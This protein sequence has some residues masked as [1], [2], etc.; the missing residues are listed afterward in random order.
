M[1][2]L[3]PGVHAATI[4]DDLVF[5]DERADRYLCVVGA[6]PLGLLG[7]EAGGVDPESFAALRA[8]GL[9]DDEA[10]LCGLDVDWPLPRRDL[11][12]LDRN[13]GVGN[14]AQAA[15]CLADAGRHYRGRTF[16]AIL[17]LGR[18]RPAPNNGT[19]RE[20]AALIRGFRSWAPFAPGASKCLL[21]A[22]MLLRLLRRE[23][24][25]A[26]WVFAVRTWPFAAHCWLQI[27]DLALDGEVER[28]A[29]YVPILVI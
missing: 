11:R 19:E 24:L 21:R 29:A 23:G 25:D 13:L 22:F 3:S 18:D 28:L 2:R 10:P 12:G 17:N 5:L 9:V 7:G 6:R 14:F 4:G 27:G 16:E 26:R 20:V 8:A 15:W 1:L